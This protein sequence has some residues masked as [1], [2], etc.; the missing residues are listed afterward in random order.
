MNQ[1]ITNNGVLHCQFSGKLDT[2]KTQ[3]IDIELKEKLTDEVKEVKFDLAQIEYISSSFL[4][5]CIA[6]LRHTGKEQFK[7]IN[8]S[9]TVLKVFQIA[10]L[11]E[12]IQVS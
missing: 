7:I 11:T 6:T 12:I 10:N 4:R 1:Y 2:L 5:I 3:T 8:V 9:P